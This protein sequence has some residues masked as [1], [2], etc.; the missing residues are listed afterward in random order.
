MVA[1][2]NLPEAAAR[3][4]ALGFALKPGQPH[5]NGIA[6]QHV[7]FPDGSELELITAPAAVDEMTTNYLEHLRGGDG[8][9]YGGFFVG[10]R[11]R[12]AARLVELQ[13]GARVSGALTTF[14]VGS[15]YRHMFF[16]GRS[17]SPT[18]RPEHFAHPNGASALSAVWI[19]TNGPDTRR[20]LSQL[21][22]PFE[23]VRV[24]LPEPIDVERGRLPEGEVLI[25]P[26]SRQVVPGR[27]IVGVTFSTTSLASVTK[28]LATVPALRSAAVTKANSVFLPPAVT[29]GV[30]IEFRQR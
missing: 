29:H 12:L 16:G 11:P 3:Y 14:P 2:R 7:K 13:A 30:W 9:A 5:A 26:G 21:G 20:L 27:R 25:L 22:V 17:K 1:V 23:K 8:P 4:K 19:A 28:V 6:N 24:D 18:D 10:D 15:S